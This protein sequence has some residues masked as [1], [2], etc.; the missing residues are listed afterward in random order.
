MPERVAASAHR[1]NSL[2]FA[3]APD[4][5]AQADLTTCGEQLRG[6][7]RLRTKVIGAERLH[8][9][10]HH[11]GEF[12]IVSDAHVKAAELAAL[13]AL[14]SVKPFEV[15]FDRVAS[16]P[17]K[18]GARPFVLLTDGRNTALAHLHQLLGAELQK[19]GFILEK[20]K[21]SPHLTLLW[22]EAQVPEE[23]IE[24]IRW[25]VN[26]V[27]LFNSLVGKSQYVRLGTWP[28]QG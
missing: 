20:R 14:R 17:R 4:A 12:P 13:A 27:V 16:F 10:L 26:E 8:I 19:Q 11:L 25:T 15:A 1:R 24:P 6:K 3:L 23:P 28:F 2:F 7:H 22:D 18:V 21:Y 9:T 5:T